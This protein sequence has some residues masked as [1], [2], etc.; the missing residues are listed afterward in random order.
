MQEELISGT[1]VEKNLVYLFSEIAQTTKPQKQ[2]SKLLNNGIKYIKIREFHDLSYTPLDEQ[3]MK[4]FVS[5]D[6]PF[7]GKYD[8]ISP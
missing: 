2:D 7:E 5:A 4:A 1:R 8:F 3:S 6:S